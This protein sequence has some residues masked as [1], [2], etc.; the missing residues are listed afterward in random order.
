VKVAQAGY[1]ETP[2]LQAFVGASDKTD[3]A[4]NVE[5]VALRFA[6]PCIIYFVFGK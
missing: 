4:T 5:T 3:L 6:V 2:V 1:R